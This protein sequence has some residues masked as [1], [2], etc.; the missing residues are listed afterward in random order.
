MK[1][2]MIIIAALLAVFVGLGAILPALAQVR[3]IGAMP[4]ASVGSYTLG[5]FLVKRCWRRRGVLC[6]FK[7]PVTVRG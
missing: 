4:K 6:F 2:V 5:V 1:K 7:T 3:D